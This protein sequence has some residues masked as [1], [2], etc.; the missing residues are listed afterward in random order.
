MIEERRTA[1]VT[2]AAGGIG[3][4]CCRAL[5]AEG[6]RV[7]VHYR[8][9]EEEARRLRDEVDGVLVQGDIAVAADIERIVEEI[10][11]AAGRLDVLVNNAALNVNAPLLMMP[12]ED[13]D[14][15]RAVTR[16]TIYLTKLVIRR[17]MFRQRSGRIINISSVV[18]HQGNAGQIPYTM[19][20]AALD[21][22]TKSLAAEL[23]D[24]GIL[25]NSVAPGFIDTRMTRELP[26][27]IRQSVIAQIPLRRMGTPEEVAEVVAFLATRGS[28]I[29]GTVIHVNGGLYR[30]G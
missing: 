16:G 9:S 15:V 5:A 1:L 3:A 13:I 8:S 19:E 4:A 7:F 25:V 14:R 26:E 20:K 21:A 12:L 11:A 18:G 23:Q 22:M 27:E 30:G 17:F 6:F 2:G 28:Y 24:R 29:T 10:R